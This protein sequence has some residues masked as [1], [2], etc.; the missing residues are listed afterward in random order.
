MITDG[1][2]TAHLENGRP[3]F[4][5]PPTPTTISKTLRAVRSCTT[6][7]ITINTF[8][9]DQS[10]YLKSF[11]EQMSKINGGRI[12]YAEPQNLGEYI[13]VDYVQNKK[14]KLTRR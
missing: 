7:N 4:A 6:K 9:L 5:Y 14:K 12:F 11:V 10:Y 3:I 8:M 13:L 2:P 1:E